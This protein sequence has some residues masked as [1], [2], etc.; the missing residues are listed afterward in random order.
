MKVGLFMDLRNPEAWRRPWAEH[1]ARSL[2]WCE[3]AERLGAD[4]VWLTE[5]HFFEDG[6]LPQ[7]LTFAAAIA[8]RTSRI[9]IGTAVLLGALRS[10]VHVAE[11]AAIVDL[12]SGGRLELGFGPGYREVEFEAFESNLASRRRRTEETLQ[13]VRDL[14][15][16]E[17]VSPGPAQSVVPMWLGYQGP[18]GAY[19]AGQLGVGL[20]SLRRSL[21]EPLRE[22]LAEGG[23]DPDDARMGG[24]VEIIV[25]DDPDEAIERIRPHYVHQQLTYREAHGDSAG[26]DAD[27]IP[28]A[29]SVDGCGLAV[30]TAEDAVRAIRLR[31]EGL[32]VE[33]VYLWA[34]IAGMPDDLVERHLEL[35]CSTVAPA[36]RGVS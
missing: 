11:E 4:A 33:H 6:Y 24:V 28:R 17:A 31:T 25:A 34:S 20:L 22:G 9:R 7:P 15:S 27:D 2:E 5:H 8:A 26:S 12:V 10:P 30:L 36:V 19:R 21:L 1:Y 23:H 18:R 29:T 14:Y 16:A 35:L 32:P 13:A 3:E